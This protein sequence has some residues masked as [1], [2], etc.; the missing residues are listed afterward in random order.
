MKPYTVME[1]GRGAVAHLVKAHYLHRWPGVVTAT[2]ALMDGSEP[3]GAIVFA[4][5]PRE[6][7]KRYR[8]VAIMETASLHGGLTWGTTINPYRQAGRQAGRYDTISG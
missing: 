5:P 7:M 1:V 8:R 4:L 3:I 2:L 6:T